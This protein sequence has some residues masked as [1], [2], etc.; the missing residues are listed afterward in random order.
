MSFASLRC[1]QVHQLKDERDMLKAGKLLRPT[2]LHFSFSLHKR[3]AYV[4][5]YEFSTRFLI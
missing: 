1:L 3:I 4:K 2:K 5:V